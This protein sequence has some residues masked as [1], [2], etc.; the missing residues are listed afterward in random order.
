MR[1]LPLIPCLLLIALSVS[2]QEKLPSSI[3]A[4]EYPILEKRCHK[5][6]QDWGGKS[7]WQ[8][9]CKLA[10]WKEVK[11]VDENGK[12]HAERR[13]YILFELPLILPHPASYDECEAKVK[14]WMLK[15]APEILRRVGWLK[16]KK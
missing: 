10:V 1:G 9:N 13:G 11:R 8:A 15:D 3:S 12:E 14:R 2:A 7:D 4:D 5:Q 6:Q 16:G